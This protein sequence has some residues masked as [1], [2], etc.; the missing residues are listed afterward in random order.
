[1]TDRTPPQDLGAEM[2]VLGGMLLSKSAIADVSEILAAADF[3]KP[4]HETIYTAI[5]DLYAEGQGADAV[6]VSAHLA[7]SGELAKAGGAP[8]LHTLMSC[9]PTAANAGHY[10]EIV[11]EHSTRRRVIQAGT[12]IAQMGWET[13][14]AAD[15]AQII[16]RAQA[17]T[18]ALSRPQAEADSTP[19]DS[20]ARVLGRIEKPSVGVPTGFIDL[21]ELTDGLH[22]G[23]MIIIAARPAIGKSTLGLD[24]CRHVS[25]DLG[26]H[27]ALFSLEMNQDEIT[28]RTL[29][30]EA[31]VPLHHLRYG[32]MSDDDWRRIG[33]HA[34]RVSSAPIHV[35]DS[36]GLTMMGIRTKARRLKQLYDLRLI[37]VDYLQLM[38]SGVPG[39]HES[40]QVEVSEISR[41]LK[42]LGK[43]L[44]L[45]V[46]AIAQLN[47]GPEQRS[48]KKPV[49]SD[50]RESGSLEMDADVVILIHREDAYERESPRAGEA[51]LIVAKNRNGATATI[52]LR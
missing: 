22:A 40:R 26:M 23:Q 28:K 11:R 37:V 20:V 42:L 47:R 34:E 6:T 4:A 39:R 24:V 3:Y 29:S 46:I 52:P 32:R 1:V 45:P 30:A 38:S 16:D 21:D 10:A 14:G 48:D 19:A 50:L 33:K 25:I 13:D 5:L 8:Y 12:R 36:P 27:T 18:H 43:E 31:S 9:I 49:L 7:K 15:L 44:D 2:A 17:E 51:D 41:G 35:D